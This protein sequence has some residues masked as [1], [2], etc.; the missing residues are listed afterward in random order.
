M[1]P[2]HLNPRTARF[3]SLLISA[4]AVAVI[5]LGS[6]AI[7]FWGFRISGAADQIAVQAPI[8]LL[9]GIAGIICWLCLFRRLHHLDSA[10]DYPFVIAL[11]F[12]VCAAA[13]AFVHRLVTGY[14]TSFGNIASA[15]Y[16]LFVQCLVAAPLAAALV[17]RGAPR[18]EADN[19][20]PR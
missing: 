14:W 19:A 6:V 3:A 20:S 1:A 12:P 13:L 7:G 18:G 15:W 4:T 9:T 10:R 17:R 5:C 8:A 2:R 11:S 16:L